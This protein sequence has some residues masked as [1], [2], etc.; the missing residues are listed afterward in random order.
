MMVISTFQLLEAYTLQALHSMANAAG[1]LAGSKK[2]PSKANLIDLMVGGFFKPARIQASLD[3]LSTLERTVLD[4]VLLAD[5]DVA[6]RTLRRQLLRSRLVTAPPEP[7]VSQ[8]PGVYA[9]VTS[10]TV[11]PSNVG[12]TVFEDLIARLTYHGLVFSKPDL[13]AVG[14][15]YKFGF[16]PGERLWIPP[17]VRRHLPK[18][19]PLPAPPERQP[20]QIRQGAPH[21][22]LRELYLYWDYVRRTDVSLLQSGLVGKRSLKALNQ[23]LLTP[24]PTFEGANSEAD[25]SKLLFLRQ[26]L[27]ALGLVQ[28]VA[29]QLRAQPAKEAKDADVLPA[30][31][32]A[33]VATQA[34]DILQRWLPLASGPDVM[35]GAQVYRPSYRAARQLLLQILNTAE[36]TSWLE[37]DELLEQLCDS[38][39]TFLFPDRINVERQRSSYYFYSAGFSGSPALIIQQMVAAERHFVQH[40]I[41]GL[42]GSLGLV[43]LGYDAPQA[44][45]W[46]AARLTALGRQIIP[47]LLDDPAARRVRERT[48][49]YNPARPAPS[50][51]GRVVVQPNFQILALGPVPL[52][53]LAQLDRFAERRKVDAGVFEYH[54]T[55]ESVYGAQ[56]GG[57]AV[58]TIVTFLQEASSG[59]LPQNVRRSLDEWGAHH[60]R[61]VFRPDV[62][63]LQTAD[64]AT[65]ASLLTQLPIRT[66][67]ERTLAP[68]VAL[69]KKS[70]EQ[71]LTT[72]LLRH[73][74]LPTIAD[75]QPTAAD[76]SVVIDEDGAITPVHAVPSLHLRGRL[77]RIAEEVGPNV[78]RL[79]PAVVRNVGGNRQRVLDLLA[80]L[81]KL[82][83]GSLPPRLV[84]Q[85]QQWGGYYGAAR[86]ATLTLLEFRDQQALADLRK[87]PALQPLLQPFA[88]GERALAVVA[89]EHL[90][91]VEHILA[92][93][94]IPVAQGLA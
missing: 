33:D 69:L 76:H 66:H 72:A 92:D 30:L 48:P 3:R 6:T 26:L 29:G 80:E 62:S 14:M 79:T 7:T 75:D 53:T 64:E 18:P 56:Q 17:E 77:A 57:L 63:L 67:L 16:E 94:R 85:I 55:R 42:L 46:Q 12:S 58:D 8:R 86:Q 83:R 81:G 1:L 68:S 23:L 21:T 45:Q 91:Q 93:L 15:A 19:H 24:D 61:I 31:W 87:L 65:L 27:E 22:F 34:H 38:A 36:T 5:G 44:A 51:V 35:A 41:D 89:P 88:A 11:S 2:K 9:P 40:A 73:D 49:S 71:Q 39:E 37:T 74:L 10:Y 20:T 59:P 47:R 28:G 32:Q 25:T 90:P 82:Q 4:A 43:E 13:S 52:A 54:L 78:W 70:R 84:E 50:D 60:E